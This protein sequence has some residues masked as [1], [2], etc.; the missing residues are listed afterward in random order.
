M[1]E[2]TLKE[3][4]KERGLRLGYIAQKVDTDNSSL[5]FAL[6]TKRRSKR[7]KEI[8]AKVE[9]YLNSLPQE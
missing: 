3:R 8:R 2:K 9:T 4:I 1:K 7:Y 6:S 5:T